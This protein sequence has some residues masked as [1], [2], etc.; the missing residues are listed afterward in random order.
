M[1]VLCYFKLKYNYI[2]GEQEEILGKR[3][4]KGTVDF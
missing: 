2:K 4:E 1:S 3:K